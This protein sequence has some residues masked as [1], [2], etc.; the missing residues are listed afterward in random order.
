MRV[1]LKE[2]RMYWHYLLMILICIVVDRSAMLEGNTSSYYMKLSPIAMYI[3][4]SILSYLI[5]AIQLYR[6]EF[7]NRLVLGLSLFLSFE[8]LLLLGQMSSILYY[9]DTYGH[10]LPFIFITGVG[11]FAMVFTQSSFVGVLSE[12]TKAVRVGSLKLLVA[13]VLAGLFSFYIQI[14]TPSILFLVVYDWRLRYVLTAD[15]S[16][17]WE[18]KWKY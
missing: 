18:F 17:S 10:I 14:I 16:K 8:L 1:A 4:C 2:I 15:G 9:Y 12:D 6:K 11:L 3:I 5:I 7:V 13:S